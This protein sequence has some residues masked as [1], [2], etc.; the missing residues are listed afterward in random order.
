MLAALTQE[1][2]RQNAESLS[3]QQTQLAGNGSANP[4]SGT[5]ANW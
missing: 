1:C 3:C 5:D 4:N 2:A